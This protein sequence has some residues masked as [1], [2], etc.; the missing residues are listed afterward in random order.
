VG[1]FQFQHENDIYQRFPEHLTSKFLTIKTKRLESRFIIMHRWFD[2]LQADDLANF[3][4]FQTPLFA[5]L[6]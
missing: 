5:I 6:C 3:N 4:F 2:C 1:G